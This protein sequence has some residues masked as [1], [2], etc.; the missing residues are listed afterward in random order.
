M[1]VQ[2]IKR[3]DKYIFKNDDEFFLKTPNGC[4]LEVKKKKH[5][6]GVQEDEPHRNATTD[7]PKRSER[8]TARTHNLA[9]QWSSV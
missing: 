9:A 8:A 3:E 6:S 2:I 5:A 7:C 1:L 4:L